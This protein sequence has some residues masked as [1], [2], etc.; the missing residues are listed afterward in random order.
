MRIVNLQAGI[1]G[2]SI[3]VM[4]ALTEQGDEGELLLLTERDI[5]ARKVLKANLTSL[6]VKES[7]RLIKN[8]FFP[9]HDILLADLQAPSQA[10]SHEL[11]YE[12]LNVLKSKR[13]L[14]FILTNS[15]PVMKEKP[16]KEKNGEHQMDP[17]FK[18]LRK[19][20]Y[21]LAHENLNASDY[22]IPQRRNNLF[23]VGA[24]DSQPLLPEPK[25]ERPCLHTIL[26]SSVSDEENISQSFSTQVLSQYDPKELYGKTIRDKR[27]GK[28]MLHSWQ[29]GL[30]GEV[31]IESQKLLEQLVLESRHEKWRDKKCFTRKENV[32]LTL[33]EI[34]TFSKL[35]GPA[36]SDSIKLLVKQGYLSQNSLGYAIAS[37]SFSFPIAHILDPLGIAPAFLSKTGER[38]GIIDK[39]LIRHLTNDEVKRLFGFQEDFILNPELSKKQIFK[40]FG[41][42]AVVP[43][44]RKVTAKLIFG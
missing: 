4:Q 31:P 14:F 26:D 43:V 44:A 10:I 29:L 34:S 24:L 17:L 2:L 23:V 3:G 36:L 16:L 28:N 30:R 8:A 5:T 12:F 6:Q 9:D 13:P 32:P 22:G 40:L 39:D 19:M 11:L 35:K 7:P 33:K 18:A 25:L 20:G 37:G 27:G 21:K 38:F 1:G 42:S 15:R 41:N